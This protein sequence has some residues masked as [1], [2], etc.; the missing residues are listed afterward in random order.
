V[1]HL[2]LFDYIPQPG[3]T[4]HA[5]IRRADE[6]RLLAIGPGNPLVITGSRDDAPMS[7]EGKP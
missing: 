7:L 3:E 5:A 6:I 2:V 1:A 4:Q